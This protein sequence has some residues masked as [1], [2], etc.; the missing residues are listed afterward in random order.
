MRDRVAPPSSF[1]SPLG[2]TPAYRL[3]PLECSPS[4]P[5]IFAHSSSVV[6]T[7]PP[8]SAACQD[9]TS[10]PFGLPA[11]TRDIEKQAKTHA[12]RHRND[13]SCFVTRRLASPVL[14]EELEYDFVPAYCMVLYAHWHFGLRLAR[15]MVPAQTPL[16]A[17][18]L[19]LMS[20]D[21]HSLQD[22]VTKVERSAALR[23]T[24]PGWPGGLSTGS[25]GSR[26]L[27]WRHV[28]QQAFREPGKA[29]RI[30]GSV[31]ILASMHAVSTGHYAPWPALL[32]LER[33]RH[34]ACVRFARP[35]SHRSG[36]TLPL[37]TT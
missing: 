36:G 32:R 21:L 27:L 5:K 23:V 18:W 20:A 16:P 15:E 6:Q 11:W 2:P 26:P 9:P 8:S 24:E 4:S 29:P 19:S 3:R 25:Q 31:G 7:G 28:R 30:S 10:C 12:D 37:L 14:K 35:V 1:P 13:A 17:R 22:V 34:G 33:V